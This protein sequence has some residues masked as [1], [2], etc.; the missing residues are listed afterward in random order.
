MLNKITGKFYRIAALA[1][2]VGLPTAGAANIVANPGFE[3][4]DFSGWTTS[5]PAFGIG[6]DTYSSDVH[7]GTYGVYFGSNPGSPA[8]ASVLDQQLA[9]VIGDQYT[10]TFW[11][12]EYLADDLGGF[13]KASMGGNVLV[14]LAD[15][16]QQDFT[17]YTA[18][19][20]AS[21]TTTLLDFQALNLPGFF[22]LDD[23]SVTDTTPLSSVPVP[24]TL[25]NL[26][27]GFLAL[28]QSLRQKKSIG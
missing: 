3:T 26:L 9:T 16:A 20:T 2:M 4:G 8:T 7:A 27:I 11:L 25:L 14:N 18:N 6:V 28:G 19:F 15:V 23:I 13:F 5:A 10:L 21:S 17:Q 12:S 22:G 1:A 24:S